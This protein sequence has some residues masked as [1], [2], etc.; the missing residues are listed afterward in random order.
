MRWLPLLLLLL[1]APVHAES[2]TMASAVGDFNGDGRADIAVLRPERLDLLRAD[3]RGGFHPAVRVAE[4]T[5]FGLLGRLVAVR[6]DADD[7]PDL[8]VLGAGRATAFLSRRGGLEPAWTVTDLTLVDA[9]AWPDS[10]SLA[11]LTRDVVMVRKLS[12]GGFGGTPRVIELPGPGWSLCANA[13]GLAVGSTG[14]PAALQV[15]ADGGVHPVPMG[16]D[17]GGVAAADFNGDGHVDFVSLLSPVVRLRDGATGQLRELPAMSVH[18][19]G[20]VA[21]FDG[22]GLPDVATLMPTGAAL[23]RGGQ[24]ALEPVGGGEGMTDVAVGDLDGDG[25]PDLVLTGL[26]R[27]EIVLL[28]N[29]GGG[30]FRKESLPLG[31]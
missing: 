29:E 14:G 9:A 19:L 26:A 12:D 4:G 18:S 28:H 6:L 15:S 10:R 25:R 27:D 3:G 16:G 24:A 23:L 20:R 13:E 11:L 2:G 7:R 8:V 5:R 21:D 22:D 30:T 17:V 31:P 1:A